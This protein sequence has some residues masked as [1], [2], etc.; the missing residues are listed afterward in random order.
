MVHIKIKSEQKPAV[1][2]FLLFFLSLMVASCTPEKPV[3]NTV[4]GEDK[5]ALIKQLEAIFDTDQN[6]RQQLM[7]LINKHGDG[8]AQV[9]AQWPKIER[10]DAANLVK[11]KKILDTH[12]WLSKE[13]VG[14]KANSA[15]F[16][17]IQ[18]ADRKTR[19]KYVPMMREAVKNQT[20]SAADLAKLEDRLALEQGK[21]QLY[22]T[23]LGHDEATN[24]YYVFPIED[25]DHIDA[26]R[27]A[28]GLDSMHRHLN[29]WGIK[30]DLEGYK[31]TP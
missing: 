17:V 11:V 26:R 12:G 28:M 2:C 24:R 27:K 23:Q 20:A 8:S 29:E 25:P 5:K 3:R 15:L 13:V 31:A 4:H 18:H 22:G 9:R 19:E 16:L 10:Q 1:P 21:K 6:P 7:T 30:W 14:D